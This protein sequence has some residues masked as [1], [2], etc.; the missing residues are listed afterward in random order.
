MWEK[1]LRCVDRL[2]IYRHANCVQNVACKSAITKHFDGLKFGDNEELT[3][4]T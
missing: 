2:C 1:I 4:S 3:N